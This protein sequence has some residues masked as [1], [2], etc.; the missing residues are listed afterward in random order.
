MHRLAGVT[1]AIWVHTVVPRQQTNQ[2]AGRC[3]SDSQTEQWWARG[4]LYCRHFLHRRTATGPR[5]PPPPPPPPPCSMSLPLFAT[6]AA[7]SFSAAALSIALS[8]PSTPDTSSPPPTTRPTP[9]PAPLPAITLSPLP[10]HPP[11]P[12]GTCLSRPSPSLAPRPPPAASASELPAVP[13]ARTPCCCGC[14]G[15]AAAPL[16]IMGI[17]S[18]NSSQYS[19]LALVILPCSLASLPLGMPLT[20][21][22]I[23]VSASTSSSGENGCQPGG[24]L[25]GSVTTVAK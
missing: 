14:G 19:S 9:M 25:P 16:A 17:C 23:P 15:P 11:L 6:I 10:S 12:P 3:M 5:P 4:G 1:E 2:K 7:N 13:S 21:A 8:P 24:T 20:P 22:C 18:S